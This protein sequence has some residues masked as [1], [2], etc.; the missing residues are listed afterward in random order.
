[1]ILT[2]PECAT[3]YLVSDTAIGP[4][5]RTVRCAACKH[6]WFQKAAEDPKRDVVGS[7][8]DLE[9]A[10]ASTSRA[11]SSRQA[12]APE[13][14]PPAAREPVPEEP[15]P[16]APAPREFS[17]G[18][19]RPESV[20]PAPAFQREAAVAASPRVGDL[21]GRSV[22]PP[23]RQARS[24][25]VRRDPAVTYGWMVAGAFFVLL[26]GNVLMWHESLQR[27]FPSLSGFYGA[28]GFG[29][30]GDAG[31][32]SKSPASLLRLSYPPP[33]P[34]TTFNGR[35]VQRISGSV[36]NPSAQ[37]VRVPKLRGALLDGNGSQVYTWTFEAPARTL[38][39]GQTTNFDVEISDFPLTAK[40]FR[41]TFET[42]GLDGAR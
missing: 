8:A 41:L 1:M 9:M 36:M 34:P 42:A 19:A 40:S 10:G 23:A 30:A 39:S 3:R 18:S 28:I 24:A 21:R 7:T 11:A 35:I 37:T 26:I 20:E 17:F 16:A 12:A 22:P 33:P 4:A 38:D 27:A 29:G 14:T 2:C 32:D 15:E 31:S 13:R 25:P 6:V 5:G